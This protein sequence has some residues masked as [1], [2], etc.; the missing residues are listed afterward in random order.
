MHVYQSSLHLNAA[1]RNKLSNGKYLYNVLHAY[2]SICYPYKLMY[3]SLITKTNVCITVAWIVIHVSVMESHMILVMWY[4]SSRMEC[5]LY[6]YVLLFHSMVVHNSAFKT[7]ISAKTKHLNCLSIITVSKKN[8]NASWP[9]MRRRYHILTEV[10]QGTIWNISKT[11]TWHL[12]FHISFRFWSHL[13]PTS[14]I[15]KAFKIPR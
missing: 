8:T 5:Q 15:S 6:S 12:W 7:T 9:T 11:S 1:I 3:P 13:T 4:P 2:M 14:Q 10:I